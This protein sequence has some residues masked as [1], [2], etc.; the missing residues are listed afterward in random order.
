M[1][2]PCEKEGL[3]KPCEPIWITLADLLALV[4]GAALAFSL[5]QVHQPQ[6]SPTWS[7]LYEINLFFAGMWIQRLYVIGEV[8][9]KQA[10]RSSRSQ[11]SRGLCLS[12]GR[13]RLGGRAPQGLHH[14]FRLGPFP[15]GGNQPRRI[16]RAWIRR[17][18]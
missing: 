7:N 2:M 5:P 13:S 8:A 18:P 12:L 6:P 1:D 11:E 17:Y 10:L 15:M 3:R 4:V 9:E 16:R 14:V